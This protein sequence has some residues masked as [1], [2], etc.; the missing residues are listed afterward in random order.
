MSDF[1]SPVDSPDDTVAARVTA[2]LNASARGRSLGRLADVAAWVAACQGTQQPQPFHRAHAIVVAGNHGVAGRGV[3]AHT[4]DAGVEQAAELAAG[5]GPASVAARAANC[6]VRLVDDWLAAPTG[7]IDVEDAMDAETFA[8]ALELGRNL[9]D[10]EV[11][12]GTDLVV[13]GDVGIGNTTV[14]AALFGTF[15]ATEPVVAVGRGSGIN[16]GA[17]KTKTAA[18]RDAMFRVRD[19]RDDVPRVLTAISGPDLVTLVGLIAQSAVRRTPVLLDGPYTAVAAYAAERLAPG[20]RRWL[21]AAQSSA[22][23]AHRVCLDALGL[24]P[25]VD[26]GMATGQATGALLALPLI[27]AAAEMAA[28][29]IAAL[30]R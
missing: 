13:T 1:F 25:L 30:Q 20:T 5:G 6:T 9:A 19:F 4:T 10:Q 17:W 14:A 11:D 8:R 15:T 21:A 22:E 27:N 23:P 24:T 7:S 29:E 18:I 28:D 12:A 3:S 26:L 2:A 16:D